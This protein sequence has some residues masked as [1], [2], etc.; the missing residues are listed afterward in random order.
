MTDIESKVH[1]RDVRICFSIAYFLTEAEA[2]EY[3]KAKPGTYNGGWF[4]GMSTGRD[5]SWD[6]VDKRDG[7]KYYATTY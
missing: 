4:H 1:H 5:P 6:Y 7:V 2:E 3:A